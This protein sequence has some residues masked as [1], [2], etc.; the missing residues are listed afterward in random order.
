MANSPPGAGPEQDEKLRRKSCQKWKGLQNEPE[1]LENNENNENPWETAEEVLQGTSVAYITLYY[2][3]CFFF[4]YIF[5]EVLNTF[6]DR[7]KK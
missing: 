4:F 3:H 6:R 1:F 5:Y 2:V 7:N